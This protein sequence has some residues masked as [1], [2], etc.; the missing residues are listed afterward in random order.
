MIW[1]LTKEGLGL[2][3]HAINIIDWLL[4][5]WNSVLERMPK[6]IESNHVRGMEGNTEQPERHSLP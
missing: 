6:V 5:S 4:E 2:Y 1:G 3:S